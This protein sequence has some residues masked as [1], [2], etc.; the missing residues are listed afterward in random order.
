VLTATGRWV[1]PLL[2]CIID[3]HSRLICHLQ[4]Y[5][6]E[7]AKVLVHGFSQALQKRKLPR[8]VM[9]DNG[10]AMVAEA[11]TAGLHALSILH[12]TTLPYSPYQNA[13]QETFWATVEGRLRAYW[14]MSGS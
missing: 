2:L 4:W 7:T 10:S 8:S 9:T 5:L 6:E 13:K 12:H 3:D 1:T 14:R 11:C